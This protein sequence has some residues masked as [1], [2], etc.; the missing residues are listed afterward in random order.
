MSWC[1]WFSILIS[2][3]RKC[4][5]SYRPLQAICWCFWRRPLHQLSQR[6]HTNIEGATWLDP[7]PQKFL[8]LYQVCPVVS[9]LSGGHCFSREYVDYDVEAHCMFVGATQRLSSDCVSCLIS[10]CVISSNYVACLM[11]LERFLSTYHVLRVCCNCLKSWTSR[12]END[13]LRVNT[14]A[15]ADLR[16]RTFLNMQVLNSILTMCC[17]ARSRTNLCVSSPSLTG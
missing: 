4:E 7:S 15:W 5:Q 3:I 11:Q 6:W 2:S 9:P 17:H 8:H 16:W 10:D 12:S 13:K 1:W 14:G